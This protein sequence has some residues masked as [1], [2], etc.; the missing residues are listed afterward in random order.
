[1]ATNEFKVTVKSP[2]DLTVRIPDGYTF[3]KKVP[4]D[5][6]RERTIEYFND[7]L[8]ANRGSTRELM[9][10]LG[11]HL[12][13]LL[14]P[15]D[16]DQTFKTSFDKYQDQ[17]LRV[18]LEFEPGAADWATLPWEFIYVPD[19]KWG[20]IRGFFISAH[21]SLILTRHVQA[22][23]TAGA[24]PAV[25][26]AGGKAKTKIAIV[27]SSPADQ[28]TV[29][30]DVIE[31]ITALRTQ[32]PD[33][34]EIVEPMLENPTKEELKAF[35]TNN[36]PNVVH[37]MG[38]GEYD[39]KNKKG[40]IAFVN[41]KTGKAQW[42]DDDTFA[43]SFAK[44]PPELVFLHACQ[45]AKS[46]SY[47]GFRGLALKLVYAGV[48]NVVAMQYP[49]ENFVALQFAKKFY[50]SLGKGMFIDQA[51][52]AG[53][54]ALG[55][56]LEEQEKVENFSDRRFGSPVVYFQPEEGFLLVKSEVEPEG[57]GKMAPTNYYCPTP[58][59]KRPLNADAV[60]CPQCRKYVIICPSCGRFMNRD[61]G[62]CECGYEVGARVRED[63]AAAS[64]PLESPI[65]PPPPPGAAQ[66]REFPAGADLASGADLPA[67]GAGH[68]SL[69]RT[70]LST[71]I[72]RGDET[73][74]KGN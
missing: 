31:S 34:I 58:N 35:I 28:T 32:Y 53:R 21:S 20:G 18:V 41:K 46:T 16:V 57:G 67:T 3:P 61:E 22:T 23:R 15:E 39:L 5:Y 55:T 2:G 72:E 70:V 19:G 59:C 24:K 4:R 37:F 71:Q 13:E 6:L 44:N 26:G 29:S 47:V 66:L 74:R 50:E 36:R 52:Q 25:T 30:P 14:F 62:A 54:E 27:V 38:H 43:D 69:L 51:V 8:G 64:K 33:Q 49:I 17:T 65:P 9:V 56:C 48:P 60:R 68:P 63:A 42:F 73:L 11:S 10:I 7:W 40:R 45:G 12:Y 1:M